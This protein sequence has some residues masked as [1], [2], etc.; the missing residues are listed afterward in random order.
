MR[1]S[2]DRVAETEGRSLLRG[3]DISLR[4]GS[5]VAVQGVSLAIAQGEF[6]ALVGPSG[7]GKSSLLFCLAGLIVPTEGSVRFDGED[8]AELT[9]EGRT[10]LRRDS[11]GFVFQNSELVPELS[12]LENVALP[13][14]LVGGRPRESKQSAMELLDG[15]GIADVAHHV[16][17]RASGGQ[18]QRAAVAR[19]M[20]NKPAVLFA[21][22]P[23]GAL[24]R[25]NGSAVAD[26]LEMLARSSGTAVVLVTHDDSI[27]SRAARRLELRDG[28]LIS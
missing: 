6:V 10:R 26:A 1:T 9:E 2:G 22:E 13:R 5:D 24:D 17:A 11:F 27:A 3:R 7:S 12:L 8:L 16:P 23:T 18:V 21:D 14:E 4:Y 20:I 15:L 25:A 19:A 28:R